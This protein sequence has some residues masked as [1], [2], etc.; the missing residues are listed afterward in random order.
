MASIKERKEKIMREIGAQR[1]LLNRNR[2]RV[3]QT[4]VQKPVQFGDLNRDGILSP[5]E[6][7]AAFK[8]GL[9]KLPS[10]IRD[11]GLYKSTARRDTIKDKRLK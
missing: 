11:K 10:P 4:P 5:S 8:R 6:L 3:T 7:A 2:G 1:G 9:N